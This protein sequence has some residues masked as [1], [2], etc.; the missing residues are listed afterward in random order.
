MGGYFY[1]INK[2]NDTTMLL[3]I[4]DSI[5]YIFTRNPLALMV[6]SITLIIAFAGLCIILKDGL[7]DRKIDEMNH[8]KDGSFIKRE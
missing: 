4:L 6:I 8:T 5:L 2:Q 7:I 3:I 1:A